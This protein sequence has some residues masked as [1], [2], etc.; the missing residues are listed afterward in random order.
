MRK[1]RQRLPWIDFSPVRS[2]NRILSK[3]SLMKTR[4]SLLKAKE[5]M[6]RRARKIVKIKERNQNLK[7]KPRSE[8]Q[9]MNLKKLKIAISNTIF[10]KNQNHNQNLNQ[11]KN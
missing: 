6:P 8:H 10:P 2:Q 1:Q 7:R 4:T 9:P 5:R 11:R 3:D